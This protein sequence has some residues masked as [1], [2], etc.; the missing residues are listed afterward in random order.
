VRPEQ[1]P[2]GLHLARTARLL[3]REF[4]GALSDA[5]GSLPVWLVLLNLKINQDANQQQLA[6]GIGEH[7]FTRLAAAA[8]AFD[9]KLRGNISPDDA[10]KLR[11]L[12][13]Q[14]SANIGSSQA[15][16]PS[17]GLIDAPVGRR[18]T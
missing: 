8:V 12:L 7:A 2:I 4:D 14:L 15:R 17:A 10:T 6:Q 5:G 13:D 16:A 9:H 18:I 3:S 11:A 1:T